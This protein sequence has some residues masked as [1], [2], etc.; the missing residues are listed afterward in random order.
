MSASQYAK[1]P[2]NS[3]T[4][5]VTSINGQ[6]GA[7]TLVA[8]SGIV[9]TP[10]AGTLTI[11]NSQAG[12]TVTS[13]SVV[14]ANGLSG[15][16]ANPTTTPAITLAPTFT[17]IVYSTGSALQTAVAGNFPTLNQNTTGTASN[18]T[19]TSNS[20]LT[21]LPS[22]SLP[23]SQVTGGPGGT[24]TSVGLSSPGV[25]YSVSGSPVT[26][27]GTLAL[28]LISQTANTF[29]AAPNGSNGTPNFRAIAAADLPSLSGTYVTQ[30][31]VGVANGVVPL[32]SSGKISTAYLPSTVLEYEGL[33]NPSTNT[34]ALSDATG[35]PGYVYWVSTAYTGTIAG[36]SNP[37]MYNFQIGDLVIYNGTQWELTTPAAGVQSVN[38]SQ[39]AVTVNA[40]NQLTGDGTAGPV[41]GSASAALTL[42]TVNSNV[43]SFALA[44][45]TVNAKGLVT[46]A[47]APTT[48]GSGNVV[49]STSPVLTSPSLDTPS[50]IT[51]T[52]ATGLPLT[53][54]VT[55]ILP[56][57][58]GGTNLSAVGASGN[59]LTSN[60]TTWISSAPATSGTVTSVG[61]SSPG[62]LYSV[63]G[64]PVTGSGTL[65]LNL[66]SQTANT[67]L[68]APNGTNGNPSFRTL[69]SADI[70]TLN[71]NTTGTA[72]NIT[73]T[74]NSTLTTLS[75][76]SLPLSQTTGTLPTANGGTNN[77]AAYTAGSVIFSNGTSL[78]QNNANFFWNNTLYQ[79]GVGTNT[80]TASA[81]LDFGSTTQGMRMPQL[82][83]TQM[84]A[85]AAPATGLEVF[86]TTQDVPYW[87]NGSAW[88]NSRRLVSTVLI[89]T[90]TTY[91]T[92][93]NVTAM[94]A[95]LV[96]AGGGGAGAG[97]VSGQG[98]AGGGGGAGSHCDTGIIAVTPSTAY[99]IAIGAGGA[100]GAAGN[101]NGA[102]G[103][104]T[105]LTVGAT[106]YT[107][108]S[109]QGGFASISTAAFTGAYGGLG[110]TAL[111]GLL[112][113]SG[114]PGGISIVNGVTYVVSGPGGNGPYGAGGNAVS[115]SN[116][117]NVGLSYG[118]GG[119]GAST[120]NANTAAGG[121]GA[122]G[123]IL[124]ELY[125]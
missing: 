42:A 99:T 6:A 51:L 40:I 36:L 98:A 85:I 39:G 74:S 18:I 14:T 94:R 2:N 91:T 117:G 26:G 29:L 35:T 125:T 38:G 71:Q 64:S 107:A 53:T 65:A 97:S 63:S 50:S 20:S 21:T 8:G 10:G 70:P 123:M 43:G 11:S 24:V 102:Y 81:A 59:V 62:V 79:L 101:N 82:T 17:G 34:P 69:V 16:V 118:A 15:T 67:V 116:A 56:A 88:V 32:N 27:S 61:L 55:G 22:L 7:L 87:Y 83:T 4:G 78:T 115:P 13:V 119:S 100:A 30:S 121:N 103:G 86:N 45:I 109:G 19:A 95:I 3:G 60:G 66:I 47:S 105:T 93:A 104:A 44:N 112:N 114:A 49:L 68:A 113:V 37:S 28:N 77:T 76:L 58:N 75:A 73:A 90:G 23:Y 9:I 54:G 25:L 72:A 122:P 92:P 41:S 84:N 46:A 31:E 124:I 52:N 108:G 80:P 110:G 106:T 120:I 5:G 48:T 1:Y 96:G 33:W 57:A 12:G 89:T 111:N